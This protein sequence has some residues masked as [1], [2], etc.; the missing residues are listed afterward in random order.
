MGNSLTFQF[1]YINALNYVIFTV[2]VQLF[3]N[4]KNV[5]NVGKNVKNAFFGIRV[6]W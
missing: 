5:K 3:L 1:L 6:Y 2:T 4:K